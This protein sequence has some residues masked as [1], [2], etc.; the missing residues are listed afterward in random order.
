MQVRPGKTQMP[1]RAPVT[2]AR[3][4]VGLLVGLAMALGL[5]WTIGQTG[6]EVPSWIALP[7]GAVVAVS[8]PAPEGNTDA[9]RYYLRLELPGEA[10]TALVQFTGGIKDA[11]WE[12]G[13]PRTA[14]RDDLGLRS[15]WPAWVREKL[16]RVPDVAA[17]RV[18]SSRTATERLHV[19]AWPAKEQCIVE[20]V[21][22]GP[23]PKRTVERPHVEE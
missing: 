17:G 7:P 4:V 2:H 14:T 16:Y 21:Q 18:M 22:E 8:Q 12:P 20:L 9:V 23:A 11:A 13:L 10:S 15:A 6:R 3:A 19:Y 1:T 5:Y